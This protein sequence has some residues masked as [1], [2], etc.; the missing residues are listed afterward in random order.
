MTARRIVAA[1][2]LTAGALAAPAVAATTGSTALPPVAAA[3]R[4]ALATGHVRPLSA[5]LPAHPTTADAAL[6]L[7]AQQ[8]DLLVRDGVAPDAVRAAVSA[9]GLLAE[10]SSSSVV[11]VVSAGPSGFIAPAGDF[12]RNGIN[13]VIDTRYARGSN[14]ASTAVIFVRD[15]SG[16][17][18][19]WSRRVAVAK[20]HFLWPI[21]MRT[22]TGG[23]PGVV[24]LDAGFTPSSDQ[25]SITVSLAL[26][27]LSRLGN[28]FWSH[29]ESGT[30]QTTDGFQ[31][32]HVP[33]FMGTP[34]AS[35]TAEDVLIARVDASRKDEGTSGSL[36]TVKVTGARGAVVTLGP[37]AS[38]TTGIPSVAAV[39]DVSG[40]RLDDIVLAIP[41]GGAQART[42]TDGK[43]VWENTAVTLYDGAAAMPAGEVHP[44]A[45]GKPA[46]ADVAV[47]TGPPPPSLLDDIGLPLPGSG[48]AG[49]HGE[50]A[51]LDGADG[52]TVW[53]RTGD[54]A[55]PVL[56][57]GAAL[58]PALGVQTS[59]V[60]SGGDNVIETLTVTAY[61]AAGTELYQHG[62]SASVP[63]SDDEKAF[64][65][66]FG[67]A[68]PI[69][70]LEPDGSADG[71]ALLFAVSGRNSTFKEV[72][73]HG[74]DG[75]P[76]KEPSGDPLGASTTGSGDDLVDVTTRTGITV[77]VRR[78][79]DNRTLFTR[80]LPGTAGAASA[81]AY[82]AQLRP[83]KCADVIVSGRNT[84]Q[85]FN[86]VLASNGQIR[87]QL[88]YP[89]NDLRAGTPGKPRVAPRPR[90]S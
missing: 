50:V 8:G 69:G 13:E 45:T 62:F 12:D 42:G 80:V 17:K 71:M 59:D 38:S 86:A 4:V 34:R 30:L 36:T 28:T 72:L 74:V 88:N 26:T 31:M 27:G 79:R 22:G 63:K 3:G 5:Y 16:G 68:V 54:F 55:Y 83:G 58:V 21:P 6:G 35:G 89:L 46:V 15:G 43:T 24:L 49:P 82:G 33:Q 9:G 41:G 81:Y 18:V 64:S 87:W 11:I 90:C 2:V 70:D 10:S 75:S 7:V 67:V 84:R 65:F 40:D 66:G 44:S 60:D 32:Q 77:T 25:K 73:F 47:G 39:P 37:S 56:R 29:R 20:N 19:L 76:L 23:A 52:S 48:Q 51:L 53:S 14:G 1:A 85:V 78:G 57:A 61:D